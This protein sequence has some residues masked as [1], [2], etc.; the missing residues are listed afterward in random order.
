ML[1]KFVENIESFA[2]Y[3]RIMLFF[4]QNSPRNRKYTRITHDFGGNLQ[5][6]TIYARKHTNFHNFHNILLN[7]H[8]ICMFLVV[9]LHDFANYTV[10]LCVF[11]YL[12]S[13][14]KCYVSVL[15]SVLKL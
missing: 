6:H 9:I 2:K 1:L 14:K 3:T 5:I 13:M 10:V 12:H 4:A 11:Q 15:I 8:D 7:K